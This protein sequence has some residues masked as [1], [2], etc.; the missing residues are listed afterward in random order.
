MRELG[1]FLAQAPS[2]SQKFP[3]L[4]E[5]EEFDTRLSQAVIVVSVCPR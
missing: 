2:S 3:L 4:N 5:L 1:K